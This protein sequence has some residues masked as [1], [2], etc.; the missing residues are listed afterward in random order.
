VT[1][2]A[3]AQRTII[4]YQVTDPA[5]KLTGKAFIVIPPR[6]IKTTPPPNQNQNQNTVSRK[7]TDAPRIKPG[8]GEQVVEMNGSKTF[9]FGQIL[10]V[11][12]GRPAS[13]GGAASSDHGKVTGSGTS[14]TFTPTKD[15]RGP[16]SVTFN[17]DDGKEDGSSVDRVTTLVLPVT[18]GSKDQSDVPPTFTPPKKQIEPG[19]AATKVDLR[20]ASYHPNPQILASLK[21]TDLQASSV[22]GVTASLSGSTLSV[23]A[24]V[25][26]KPGTTA[27]FHFTVKS[28]K[29]S[30]PGEVDVTVTSSTR[31]LAQQKNPPQTHDMKRGQSYTLNAVTDKDWINPFPDTPLTI[32]DATL[33]SAPSG[34]SISHTSSAI[35]VKTSSGKFLGD[36]NITY[37]VQ[38]ATKD[39]AR[40]AQVIGQL[41]VTIHD[42]PDAPKTP[43]VAKVGTS[44]TKQSTVR[45]SYAAPKNNGKPITGYTVTGSGGLGS[46]SVGASTTSVQFTVQNGTAYTFK[47][48]AKNADG[49]SAASPASASITTYGDPA[50]PG[51]P[52]M[53]DNKSGTAPAKITASWSGVSS[54]QS[55]G[56]TVS[57]QVSYD[58][59]SPVTT[60]N[61]SMSWTKQSAGTHTVKVRTIS[62]PGNRTS[63]WTATASHTL[64]K[65]DPK[66]TL[67]KGGMTGEIHNQYGDCNAP[68]TCYYYHVTVS[69]FPAN[70]SQT[71][72][73]FCN[74]SENGSTR[75]MSVGG[76]GS[77]TYDTSTS[78]IKWCGFNPASVTVNGVSSGNKDFTG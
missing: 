50:K 64:K 2:T 60:S 78:P 32:T 51:K 69:N 76:D 4:P 40:T 36:V 30:I 49:P 56:G 10:V 31:P 72:H 13:L 71:I 66:V 46:T 27:V 16:A 25:T 24:P 21:Y 77:G 23:Q 15:Y 20:A 74:G 59:G 43:T 1:V 9:S 22:N 38:D 41:K 58:G 7:T 68:G 18:V 5:T 3:Q 70:S 52:S 44:T 6:G 48:V 54:S 12:W 42:V 55:G 67:T 11:P 65:P 28:D 34:V 14:F 29:F 63:A 39:P 57:Y 47:V 33:Q 35:T 26:T 45:V 62:Q 37:H 73:F 8:I 61:T 19:E 17:V 53:T 75:T